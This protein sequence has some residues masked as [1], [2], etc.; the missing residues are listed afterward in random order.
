[1]TNTK[2]IRERVAYVRQAAVEDLERQRPEQIKA[3]ASLAKPHGDAEKKVKQRR[4]HTT[5]RLSEEVLGLIDEF[6]RSRNRTKN[7]ALETLLLYGLEYA[8]MEDE[9]SKVLKDKLVEDIAEK[10]VI[11]RA[12]DDGEVVVHARCAK[13]YIKSGIVAHLN[14]YIHDRR[15]AYLSTDDGAVVCAY[16]HKA[17]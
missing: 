1:M 8:R 10:K 5:I 2:V 4:V 9:V 13:R 15:S 16:C 7:N 14:V 11:A 6:A 12:S 3:I 17:V